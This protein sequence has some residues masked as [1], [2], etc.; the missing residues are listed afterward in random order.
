MFPETLLTRNIHERGCI[1]HRGILSIVMSGGCGCWEQ[2][3]QHQYRITELKDSR[4]PRRFVRLVSESFTP[5]A[6]RGSGAHL[7]QELPVN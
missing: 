7:S 1:L 3:V 2:T 6:A 5:T 4:F